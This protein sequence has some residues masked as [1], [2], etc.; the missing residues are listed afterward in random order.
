MMMNVA[1]AWMAVAKAESIWGMFPWLGDFLWTILAVGMICLMVYLMRRDGAPVA[2]FSIEVEDEEVRFKGRFP[3]GMEGM[4]EDFLVN[5]CR[6]AGPYEVIG[7]WEEGRLTVSVRGEIAK[8]QEQRIR[9]FL[10]LNVKR[11]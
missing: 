1:N 7:K 4:V 5:D 6:I 11:A 2:D 10:K 3:A 8:L 9:N